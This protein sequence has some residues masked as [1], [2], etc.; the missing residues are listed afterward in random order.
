MILRRTFRFLG[1]ALSI[2]GI[3]W[4]GVPAPVHAT[5]THDILVLYY[6][7]CPRQT[8]AVGWRHYGCFHGSWS[9]QQGGHW[10][11]VQSMTCETA[12]ESYEY[13]EFCNGGWN[14]VSQSYFWAGQCGC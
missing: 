11:E 2:L 14:Q 3:A 8:P 10:K 13:Y 5:P 4:V 9:G 6:E 7:G 1:V 12:E